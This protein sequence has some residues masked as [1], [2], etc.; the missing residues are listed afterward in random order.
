MSDPGAPEKRR[1]AIRLFVR[2]AWGSREGERKTRFVTTTRLPMDA[3][4]VRHAVPSAFVPPGGKTTLSRLS[5]KVVSDVVMRTR[6]AS[7]Q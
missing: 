6:Y 5:L 2:S 1:G 3:D 4:R 7:L